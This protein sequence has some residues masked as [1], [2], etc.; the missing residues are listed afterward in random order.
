MTPTCGERRSRLRDWAPAGQPAG[1]VL[2][3]YFEVKKGGLLASSERFTNA[4]VVMAWPEVKGAKMVRK[5]I[6]REDE[7]KAAIT[8]K[9]ASKT[10]SKG[11]KK[12][13]RK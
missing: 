2:L 4:D 7:R 3:T 13:K 5:I 6:Y 12:P 1:D 9:A 10:K 11:K 8:K